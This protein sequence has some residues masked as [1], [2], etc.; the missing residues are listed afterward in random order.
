MYGYG[1]RTLEPIVISMYR[2]SEESYNNDENEHKIGEIPLYIE[3]A[4][5]VMNKYGHTALTIIKVYGSG[6]GSLW[7]GGTRVDFTEIDDMTILDCDLQNAYNGRGNRNLYIDAPEF[8]SLKDG[9]NAVSFSG[10]ITRIQIIPRW[11]EL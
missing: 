3:G 5:T 2:N 11:W 9:E 6:T 4:T 10:G 1:T 7:V 8:P